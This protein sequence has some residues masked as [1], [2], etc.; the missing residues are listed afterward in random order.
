MPTLTFTA[1]EGIPEIAFGDDL[2]AL[3][4]ASLARTG[5]APADGDVLVLAQKIVSKSEGRT[6]ALATVEPGARARE[7]AT[8]TGKDPRL[9]ELVL[10]ESVAVLRAKRDVIVV[11]H[12]LGWIMANA[13][14]DMSNVEQDGERVLLLPE[15]P[16]ATCRLLRERL[17]DLASFGLIINDSFGRAWRNG[18]TGT[19]LGVA[20][21]PGVV[22]LRG[23]RDRFGRVL[24]TT[25]VAIADEI[26]AGA[27]ALMGQGD[28]GTPII[29]VRGV[30]Y[31]RREGNGR[32][33]LRPKQMDMFR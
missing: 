3:I 16:D 7:L 24:R 17:A 22:D 33:L 25:E 12:R 10:A 21:L 15:D 23:Q 30:P 28:E 2:A 13:G 1:L 11:E 14:I 18:V 20:G 9:I 5:I 6:V 31:A 4:R 19:A 29:H 32:E 27:S 26:A 8:V